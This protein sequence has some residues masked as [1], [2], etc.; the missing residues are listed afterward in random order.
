M[1]RNDP[2]YRGDSE[3]VEEEE[4]VHGPDGERVV[5]RV[6]KERHVEPVAPAV[7]ELLPLHDTIVPGPGNAE[8]TPV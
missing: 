8:R 3:T 4:V 6:P 2:Y 7:C 5:T 1:H